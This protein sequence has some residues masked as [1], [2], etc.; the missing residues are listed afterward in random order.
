VKRILLLQSVNQR[1]IESEIGRSES[2]NVV[3]EIHVTAMLFIF[4]MALASI[5]SQFLFDKDQ[6]VE[7]D[8]FDKRALWVT[9]ASFIAMNMV[10][11]WRA[12]TRS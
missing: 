5:Y 6:K 8:R 9:L 7:A 2:V 3:D 10:L 4:A 12:A 1:V 11:I